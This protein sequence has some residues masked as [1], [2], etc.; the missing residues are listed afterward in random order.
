MTPRLNP[1]KLALLFIALPACSNFALAAERGRIVVDDP[2]GATTLTLDEDD[3]VTYTGVG[4]AIEASV[5][6]NAVHGTGIAVTAYGQGMTAGV[7]A[8][9]GGG[10]ALSNSTVA[11]KGSGFGLLASDPGS[12][13]HM[14]NSAITISDHNAIGASAQAGARIE[15][16]GGSVVTNGQYSPNLGASG[17]GSTIVARDVHISSTGPK[18][19]GAAAV[20]GG[21][22]S[23]YNTDIEVTDGVGALV[24]N[25]R[26]MMDGGRIIASKTAVY[27]GSGRGSAARAEI[28]NAAFDVTGGSGVGLNL[29]APGATAQIDHVSITTLNTQG[30]GVWLSSEDT[31]LHATH[32]QIRSSYTGVENGGGEVTL[33]DGHVTIE[34]DHGYGLYSSTYFADSAR[35]NASRVSVE[36]RGD[37]AVGIF[38]LTKGADVTLDTVDV[39]SRGAESYGLQVVGGTLAAT[40]STIDMIGTG[41]MAASVSEGGTVTLDHATV[42]VAE[43]WG[44]DSYNINLFGVPPSPSTTLIRNGSEITID[45]GIA[46]SGFG[47]DHTFQVSDSQ[48]L[49]RRTDDERAATL[50]RTGALIVDPD[51]RADHRRTGQVRLDAANARLTGDVAAYDGAVDISL[52]QGSVLTGALEQS[53]DGRVNGLTLDDTSA[54][55]VRGDSRLGTLTNGGSVAF[56][57]PADATGFKTL[58]V[59][60]YAG[61]GALLLHTRLGG[62]NSPTDRLVIDG[63]AASGGTSLR[64][65]NA[66]GN[67]GRTARGIRVVETVNGG[68]TTPDAFRLDSAS[69]G[70][71]AGSG[72]LSINGYDYSLVRGGDANTAA[73]WF[74]SSGGPGFSNVSPEGGAYAG[75]RQAAA[76]LFTHSAHDRVPTYASGDGVGAQARR[77]RRLWLR[78]QGRHDEGLRLS[79][80]RVD[81]DTDSAMLQLGGDLLATPAGG[82][83]AVHV[84]LMGGYGDARSRSVST[85]ALSGG[86]RADV[87]ARGKVSGYAAGLYATWY[88]NDLTRRG[89]WADAWVQYGRYTNRLSS[90]LG[91]ADYRSDMWSA[92][93]EAGYAFQPFAGGALLKTLVVEP[94]AQMI[95]DHYRA[96]DAVVSDLRLRNG[97]GGNWQSRIG[98]RLHPD[99]ANAV[100]RPFLEANWLHTSAN[101]VVRMGD[102]SPRFL[103]ARNA[104]ELKAGAQARVGTAW[105]LSAQVFEQSGNGSQRSYGGS[106][107]ASYRW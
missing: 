20:Q 27:L 55:T 63:G 66:D 102:T 85:L 2:G 46:L 10:V 44:I 76:N 1:I 65:V 75:N 84:G 72:T 42:H 80:G 64:I 36:T 8:H 98:A 77:G 31:A 13:I 25:G 35:L 34:G 23:A 41:G 88:Q 4:G 52:K 104:F 69:T 19:V 21:D 83:G 91:A 101:P 5:A 7:L 50:L 61:G 54:W 70:Y 38:A 51:G 59:N 87:R 96:A 24:R 86:Q 49:V 47:G 62:D 105:R 81:V 26:F 22:I 99:A 56:A 107:H 18:G 103:S 37:N 106:V 57:A 100:I 32:F 79:E 17:A 93:L 92:S 3:T 9:G 39:T 45:D 16:N 68:T 53:G 11:F 74:L 71:R 67:G 6:G 14:T 29:D 40:N 43:G 90:E 89:A 48:L 60:D 12:S 95:Y 28:N 73:D 15:L 78:V 33:G 97:A 30:S 94:H 82:E 58:T